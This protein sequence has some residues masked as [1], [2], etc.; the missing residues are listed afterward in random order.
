MKKTI[1]PQ[2]CLALSNT[3]FVCLH[4]D[5]KI[6]RSLAKHHVVHDS[7]LLYVQSVSH[8]NLLVMQA[9]KAI[10]Q[11]RLI[12][13]HFRAAK[14]LPFKTAYEVVLILLY[15]LVSTLLSLKPCMGYYVARVRY[16]LGALGLSPH[17]CLAFWC[18]P[19]PWSN[20]FKY[21]ESWSLPLIMKHDVCDTIY[22][23]Y[24]LLVTT[25]ITFS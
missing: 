11:W 10:K 18:I 17:S 16:S 8:L 22:W 25:P 2:R 4:F 5:K 13:V 1:E 9:T 19:L 24:N 6:D 20:A 7:A 15:R 12:V 14:S 3:S 23:Q 21:I